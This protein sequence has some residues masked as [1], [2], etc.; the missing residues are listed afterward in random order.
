MNDFQGGP[1]TEE[2]MEAVP[3]LQEMNRL[4]SRKVPA[5]APTGFVPARY[6]HYL[7]KARKSGDETAFRH[8]WEPCVILCLRDGL[9]SG[10]VF[11]PGSR[12]YADPATYLYT[13]EQWTPRQAD[14][15]RLVGKPSDPAEALERLLDDGERAWM[16]L[17]LVAAER[18]L[19]ALRF[20]FTRQREIEQDDALFLAALADQCTAAVMR[21]L[22]YGREYDTVEALKRS[23]HPHSL[24]MVDG[25][26][27]ALRRFP[28]S[29]HLRMGEDL[30]D[31]FPLHDGRVAAVVGEA[32]GKGI[33]AATR[34][35]R[36]RIMVRA[37]A[38]FSPNGTAVLCN[39]VPGT[40]PLPGAGQS[41]HP[42]GRRS[43]PGTGGHSRSCHLHG[44]AG[45]PS[46]SR[47]NRNEST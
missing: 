18:M 24:P 25:L 41:E 21:A 6:A 5:G 13:P 31:A 17:P 9:R 11:M 32:M 12:R 7:D 46:S 15:C 27:L 33:D 40:V 1:G 14:Y 36:S 44:G 19:G 20:S 2:L 28:G 10:D 34:M 16:A 38:L 47:P 35:G 30:F 42:A 29:G 37:L 4:G 39:V 22:A 26:T 45:L 3:I 8:Y 23:L 43:Y